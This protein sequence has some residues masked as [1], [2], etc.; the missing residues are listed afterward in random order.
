MKKIFFSEFGRIWNNDLSEK[1]KC[2]ILWLQLL[3]IVRPLR[4]LTL[5]KA[6]DLPSPKETFLEHSIKA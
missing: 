1:K 3:L 6:E 5:T 4:K 2:I